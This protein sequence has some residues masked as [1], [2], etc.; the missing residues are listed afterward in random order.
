[1]LLLLNFKNFL[2]R[3]SMRVDKTKWQKTTIAE[4]GKIITG[5]TPPTKITAYYNSADVCFFKPGDLGNTSITC[6]DSSEDYISNLGYE[7]SRKLPIGTVLVTCIGIIGKVGI[8]SVLSTCNQQINAIICNE[9]FHNRFIAYNILYNKDYFASKANG[10]VVPLI[11][12]TTFSQFVLNVPISIEEQ[13]NIAKE[14]DAIQ[15][16]IDGYNAQLHDLDELI[17]SIFNDTFGEPISNP[18][19]W[20]VDILENIVSDDCPITYGIVQPGDDV[21]EGIPVVRPVDLIGTYVNK[22][23]LKKVSPEISDSYKRTILKGNE[24]LIC[25]RGTTGVVSFATEDM[26]GCNVTRG[27]V[28]LSFIRHNKWFMYWCIKSYEM[29]NLIQK[30]TK[31]A[32]LKQINIKDLR[33]LPF[34]T[35]PLELQEKFGKQAELIETQ[36][37]LLNQQ[38]S[39]ARNL[40]AERMQY[41]FS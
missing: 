5:A 18:K 28:P 4:I 14:L 36:R 31:G 39:D 10:P 25:V 35:P 24:I 40:M 30:Y 29:N 16:M 34:P 27:I 33:Q 11:N 13:L 26:K 6:L 32:T 19:G 17:K 9:N 38:I 2:I 22:T 21:N 23:F 41:Y 3:K 20:D 8:T 37:A 12:K 15:A 1:M 7:N